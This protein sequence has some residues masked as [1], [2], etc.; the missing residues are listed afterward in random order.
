MSSGVLLK[1]IVR[2]VIE[3]EVGPT[4]MQLKRKAKM[5]TLIGLTTKH[6]EII[7]INCT[8]NLRANNNIL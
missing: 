2:T 7:I 5:P 6:V 4:S 8:K 1:V 3:S